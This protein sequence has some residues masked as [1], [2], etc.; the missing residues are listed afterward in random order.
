MI[1]NIKKMIKEDSKKQ[2]LREIGILLH[3]V[4]IVR[5]AHVRIVSLV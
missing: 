2:R 5:V 4:I 3:S 1:I